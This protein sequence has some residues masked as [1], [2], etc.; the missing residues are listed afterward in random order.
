MGK[1]TKQ[2]EMPNV[3]KDI[4]NNKVDSNNE[5]E[6][7]SRDKKIRMLLDSLMNNEGLEKKA[8]INKKQIITLTKGKLFAAKYNIPIVD[9]LVDKLLEFSISSGRA[10]RKELIELG[11]SYADTED[12]AGL[13]KRMSG[14]E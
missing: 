5:N 14:I 4:F 6:E 11:K 1:E 2:P 13:L 10:G 9:D 3:A 12:Q 7:S 8:D